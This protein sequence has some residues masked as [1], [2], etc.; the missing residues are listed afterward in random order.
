M[1]LVTPLGWF[2]NLSAAAAKTIRVGG[3]GGLAAF[4]GGKRPDYRATIQ[5][6]GDGITVKGAKD[7]RF[8][9]WR[10]KDVIYTYTVYCRML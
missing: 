9:N 10:R 6:R 2:W 1:S 3:A 4:F 5:K 7:E 8:T